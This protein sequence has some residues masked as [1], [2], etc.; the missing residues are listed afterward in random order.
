ML[1]LNEWDYSGQCVPPT[2]AVFRMEETFSIGIFQRI[3]RVKRD[4]T[5]LFTPFGVALKRGPVRFRIKGYVSQPDLAIRAAKAVCERLN[6]GGYVFF[7]TSQAMVR[8]EDDIQW[9]VKRLDGNQGQ[10]FQE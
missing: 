7:D 6:K 10:G 5:E 2:G 3:A 8:S 1:K 9:L 4:G